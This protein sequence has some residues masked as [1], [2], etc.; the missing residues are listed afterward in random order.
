MIDAGVAVSDGLHT[1]HVP[2]LHGEGG[3]VL[4]LI[5]ACAEVPSGDVPLTVSVPALDGVYTPDEAPIEPALPD[6]TAHVVCVCLTPF[7][8]STHWLVWATVMEAGE[9]DALK[10]PDGEPPHALEQ[11]SAPGVEVAAHDPATQAKYAQTPF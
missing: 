10:V 8:S 11:E 3:G 7:R 4:T 1:G 5:V 6:T 9:Q 2:A